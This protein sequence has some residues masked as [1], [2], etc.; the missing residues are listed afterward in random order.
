[1][2][3]FKHGIADLIATTD[4]IDMQALGELQGSGWFSGSSS[5]PAGI[6]EQDEVSLRNTKWVNSAASW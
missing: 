4:F 6:L 5:C 2:T 1:M 3:V